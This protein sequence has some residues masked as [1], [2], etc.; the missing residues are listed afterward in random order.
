MKIFNTLNEKIENLVV[1]EEKNN[2]FLHIICYTILGIISLVMSI[3]NLF[4]EYNILTIST[5]TFTVL[6]I[7][8]VAI[9]IIFKRYGIRITRILFGF[10]FSF[11]F[12]SFIFIGQPEGF[13]A[14]WMCILPTAGLFLYGVKHGSII[15][16]LNFAIIIF[17]FWT[18]W[19]KS[20]SAYEYSSAFCL[21]FPFLYISFF[22]I[23]FFLENLRE[24]TYSK[25]LELKQE[26]YTLS[27]Y[28]NLTK[29]YNRHGI[30]SN[31]KLLGQPKDLIGKGIFILDIDFFK[32]VNDTYGHNN[33]DIVL[34]G[35]GD[36]INKMFK[37]KGLYCRWGGE[38]FVVILYNG[39]K[40]VE[41]AENLRKQ[42][43]SLTFNLSGEN[44]KV[45]ISIGAIIIG[46]RCDT[47]NLDDFI[48]EADQ[49]LYKAKETGRN[50]TI[51]KDIF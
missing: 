43:E 21:R 40:T 23:G 32:N 50:K 34:A 24:L 16:L 29:I 4:F 5:F 25:L 18:P 30:Y 49:C 20:L 12:I 10:E 15:S 9:S 7:I 31:F 46:E 37:D 2:K 13:S 27:Q 3:V 48:K 39:S 41:Y 11:L 36:E 8:N 51:N 33:G 28:D 45:T 22:A 17:A 19:G 14:I 35:I 6:C 47:T 44:V 38:E 1:N 42:I 26:Y